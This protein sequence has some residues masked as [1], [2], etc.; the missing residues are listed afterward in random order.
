[1]YF[2]HSTLRRLVKWNDARFWA[3]LST[4][5]SVHQIKRPFTQPDSL[6][7]EYE[8]LNLMIMKGLVWHGCQ[9]KIVCFHRLNGQK[10]T[11]W[12]DDSNMIFV[13]LLFRSFQNQLLR[14]CFSRSWFL[15]GTAVGNTGYAVRWP[16]TRLPICLIEILRFSRRN[17]STIQLPAE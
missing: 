3:A 17:N 6:S 10:K 4:T 14:N 12:S 8:F 15:N 9:L 16:P 2:L 11:I 7:S 1:M 13:N 5:I